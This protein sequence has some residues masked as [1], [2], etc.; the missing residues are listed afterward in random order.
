[1][2]GQGPEVSSVAAV[3]EPRPPYRDLRLGGSLGAKVTVRPDGSTLVVSREALQPYPIRL[4]DRLRHWAEITP[5]HTL[6]AK[7]VNGGDWRTLS[8]SEALR[9]ARAIA[10]ALLHRGLSADQPLVILSGNDIEHLLLGLGAMVAGVPY[11]PISP[12][13]SLLSQ[14]HGKL[15][16]ILDLLTPGLVFANDPA[17]APAIATAVCAKTPVVLAEGAL[18]ERETI[19]FAELLATDVTTAVDA[20][21]AA[22]GPD[23]I[24]KFL[25]TSGSTKLPKGVI[26]TQRMLCSNQQMIQQWFPVLTSEPPVLVDWLPWHHTFGGN[27]CLNLVIYNGGTLFVDDGKPTPTL[28]GETVRN[29]REVAPTLYFNVPKGLEELANALELDAALRA[30]FFSRVKMLFF[31]AAGLSQP[32]WDK[33]DTIA[34]Q[35]CG[36]RIRIV[37]GLGMTET[38]PFATCATGLDVKSGHI[39]LPSAGLEM[40]LVPCDGKQEVR[41]RG[42]TVTPGY[43]RAPA[44]T[45]ESFDE[46]GFFRGGDALLPVDPNEPER[47]FRFDGRIAEDFKLDTGTFVSVGP[48]RAKIIA[49][50][51]PLIQ[52]VAV[53]G[54]NR[55]EIGVLVFPR[56]DACRTFCGVSSDVPVEELLGNVTLRG[57]FQSLLDNLYSSSTGSSTLVARALVLA[58]PPSVD[59]GEMTDKGSI[60][61]RAVLTHRDADVVRLYRGTYEDV[62]RPRQLGQRHDAPG[63]YLVPSGFA[64]PS[65]WTSSADTLEPRHPDSA[66]GGRP[67]EHDIAGVQEQKVT[68][69]SDGKKLA[70]LLY[71]PNDIHAGQKKPAIVFARP[72]SGVKEQTAGLYARKFASK[73][74]ITLAFDP[75]GF[76]ESEGIPQM[77]DP[78][79]IISDNKNAYTF[80]ESLPQVDADRLISAGVCM[81]AGHAAAASSDDCRIKATVCISSYLTSQIDYPKAYGGKAV[82]TALMALSNPIVNLFKNLGIYFNIPVVPFEKWMELIPATETQKGMKQYY[83]GVGQPG[84]TP[85]WKNKVNFYHASNIMEG[86]YSPFDF[87]KRFINRPFYMAYADGGYSV[88]KLQEFYDSI[89]A[90]SKELLVSKNANHFDLYYKPEFVDAIVDGADKF[91]RKSLTLS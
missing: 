1:M 20:A 10:Q 62:I 25:F 12:A 24:A 36:E 4:T 44:Q 39:G 60:N 82:V 31:A 91:L 17:Y 27:I 69:D 42:P 86:R 33:L 46:E 34:E 13:Y 23:T 2:I 80:L 70:A 52:D 79:S 68:F 74:Y 14:D 64:S 51:D 15:K 38:A 75:K 57:F 9:G 84:Y 30:T 89:P 65:I 29:L 71:I 73:G 63:T 11:A 53:A 45:A 35:A 18:A 55:S 49:E 78:F 85:N 21:Y 56:L 6:L 16:H 54:L 32:V 37:T 67:M 72:A 26:N 7:R 59:K 50:G 90:D 88:D 22:V 19:D 77:E 76:G 66:E 83:G 5:E 48:L 47:G 81:G 43:W 40:K 61:Q 3:G 8:Y 58:E 87:I 28:I 41:Y